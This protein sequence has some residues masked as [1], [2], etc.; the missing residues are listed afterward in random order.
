MSRHAWLSLVGITAVGC[1][2]SSGQ[3]DCAPEL[4]LEVFTDADGDGFGTG[5]P[6]RS[7]TL[8]GFA[9]N[10][11]DCDDANDSVHPGVV[12]T[13]NG[14]DDDC[15]GRIDDQLDS[16]LFYTDADGDGFGVR[17]PAMLG[18]T[19]PGA[20]WA[21]NHSDCDDTDASIHPDGHEVCNDGVDDDCD[22]FADDAD[23]DT[24][25]Q[26]MSTFWL[27]DDADGLGDL[28]SPLLSC[29]P[30]STYVDN[31]DD[32]DDTDAAITQFPFFED[33]DLDGYG[34]E[35][36]YVLSCEGYPGGADNDLDCDDTDPWINV[37]HDW[38]VDVDGDG[39]G[40]GASLGFQ[41]DP[42][43]PGAGPWLGDCDESDPNIHG[44]MP[45]DCLDGIDQDCDRLIDCDDSDCAADPS[46]LA[47]CADLA[48]DSLAP[49]SVSG[50]TL[51]ASNSLDP[52]CAYSSAP[53]MVAQW[54][55]PADGTY[56]I[57]TQGSSYDTVLHAYSGCGGAQLGCN[58]DYYGLQSRI[59][60]NLSEGDVVMIVV[61]GYS[62]SSG[63]FTLNILQ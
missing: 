6:Q 51:G 35:G 3:L 5:D 26:S 31:A 54:V 12:E 23:D 9:E 8:E 19:E 20:G 59:V 13:C 60:L 61:D 24:D 44:G 38:Y 55:A 30:R 16:V 34:A 18:C 56:R 4:Q 15:N 22:G 41:C 25:P 57:N 42:P 58:D 7:C 14:L 63:S 46:C 53:D 62:T 1:S 27:D 32:C 11:L 39:W 50:S 36:S 43:A 52:G 45:E 33:A 37:P 10:R 21:R 48:L 28:G 17:Y 2:G 49:I 47:P 29:G 40:T